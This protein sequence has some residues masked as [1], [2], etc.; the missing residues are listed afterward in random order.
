M[1]MPKAFLAD[2]ART[3]Q[4]RLVKHRASPCMAH[5][6]SKRMHPKQREY[7]KSATL[8]ACVKQ[9]TSNEHGMDY[10]KF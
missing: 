3:E 6:N 9:K 5:V 4:L 2:A 8:L 7:K 10:D 1:H